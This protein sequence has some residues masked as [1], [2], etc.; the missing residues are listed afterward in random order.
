METPGENK[1]DTQ[2]VEEAK[3]GIDNFLATDH[4]WRESYTNG[5]KT[6]ATTRLGSRVTRLGE[7][8]GWPIE[9]EIRSYDGSSSVGIVTPADGSTS[10][11]SAATT[12]GPAKY[13]A[14][15]DGRTTVGRAGGEHTFTDKNEERARELIASL[16]VKAVVRAE[17]KATEEMDKAA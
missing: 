7:D 8:S 15:I 16:A 13:V 17:E 2:T 6:S 12:Q 10:R 1:G 14:N 4:G 11:V 5:I 9:R 3:A